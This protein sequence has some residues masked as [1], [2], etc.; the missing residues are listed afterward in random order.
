MHNICCD[1]CHSHVARC[2]D[3]MA[4]GGHR[5]WNMIVLCFWMLFAGKWV[6]FGRFLQTWGPF[7]FVVG[8]YL[9]VKYAA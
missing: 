4:Y 9:V 8:I 7:L 6:S 1:N 2:L 5:H 3:T